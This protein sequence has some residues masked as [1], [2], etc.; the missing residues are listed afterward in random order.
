MENSRLE[1][2]VFRLKRWKCYLLMLLHDARWV[3]WTYVAIASVLAI[4]GFIFSPWIGVA[5]LGLDAFLLAMAMNLVIIA[6]GF[7]TLTGVNLSPHS[8]HI[9]GNEVEVVPEDGES[10]FLSRSDFMPYHIYPGGVLLPFGG[11]RRGWLWL[12]ASAF[13]S[14][15]EMQDFIKAI[16]Q[17]NNESNSKQEPQVLLHDGDGSTR[18]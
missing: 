6:Y 7:H 15:P 13:A 10:L 16:Y 4:W 5:A 12:P 18:L 3:A 9:E 17:N 11:D 8:I 1:S 14:G 2:G